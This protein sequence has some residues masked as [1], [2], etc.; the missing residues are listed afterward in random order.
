MTRW[1]KFR[2][3]S[4]MAVVA[5]CALAVLVIAV[6]LAQVSS[7]YRDPA[8]LARAIEVTGEKAG[9]GT[10][11]SATCARLVFPA[12]VCSA[13]FSSGATVTVH[14]QVAA[15]GSWWHTT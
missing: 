13:A 10:P 5:A 8:I 4:V 2:Y 1:S 11:T 15:D 14:V 7:D 3:V 9:D 12:Y 6:Q